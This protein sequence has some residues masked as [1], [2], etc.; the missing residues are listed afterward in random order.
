MNDDRSA[1]DDETTD[2]EDTRETVFDTHDDAVIAADATGMLAG[3]RM[4][5]NAEIDEALEGD[6]R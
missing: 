2:D 6:R 1:A 5:T 4:I 3:E